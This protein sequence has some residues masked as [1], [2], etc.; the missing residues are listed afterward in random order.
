MLGRVRRLQIRHVSAA[1][2]IPCKYEPQVLVDSR[3]QMSDFH[4]KWRIDG[5]L[6]HEFA[7]DMAVGGQMTWVG[8]VLP[9][10][11]SGDHVL[12]GALRAVP[13]YSRIRAALSSIR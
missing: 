5:E 11:D 1:P 9:T 2:V 12:E 8:S 7:P 4:P 3:A 10:I 13:T 6:P